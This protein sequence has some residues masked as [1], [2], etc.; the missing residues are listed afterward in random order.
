M[1][2]QLI[3]G[4]SGSGKST[5]AFDM[6]VRAAAEDRN[7]NVYVLV[8]DQFS[9]EATRTLV[10]K[11]N[12]GILNIDVLSFRRLAF[13]ALEE[14]EG[15]SRSIL[16]DEGKIMLLRKVIS[17]HKT[18]LQYFSKG[19]DRPGFLDECKSLL[20]EFIEYGIGD[21]ELAHLMTCFGEESRTALKLADLRLLRQ[22]L[23]DRLGETYRMA[24]E[25]IPMLTEMVPALSFLENATIC[26]DDF[27]GFTPVQFELLRALLTRCQDVIVTVTTDRDDRR[28]DVFAL[29]DATVEKLV[30]IASEQGVPVNDVIVTGD[31]AERNSY[32]LK[33]NPMLTYLE[34]HIFHED[35]PVYTGGDTSCIS[36]TACRNER[37][38]SL[39][40]ARQVAALLVKEDV[41][42]DRIAVV[43]G[44]PENYEP[45]LR[46]AFE[47]Y[48]IPYFIDQKKSL[49]MNPL[50]EFLLSFLYMLRRGFDRES[51]MRFLRGGLSA[52]TP[53]EVD[54]LENYM[55]ASG[56]WG[57]RSLQSEW[58]YD[59]SG[60][61][62]DRMD[63]LNESRERFLTMISE[64]VD[65]LR[66]GKK[67]VRTFT[68]ILVT[69]MVKNTCRIRLEEMADQWEESGDE[70]L[71]NEYRRIYPSMLGVMD[72]LVGLLGSEEVTSTE[73]TE[74]LRAGISEGVLGFVPPSRGQVLIGDVERS[75]LGDVEHLFF[76]GNTDAFFPKSQG[77]K[78]ILTDRERD[79]IDLYGE[80][81][82]IRL[83]PDAEELYGQELFYLYHLITRPTHKLYLTYTKN[84][85]SGKPVLP[86][87]LI[88]R[89]KELF[90]LQEEYVELGEARNPKSAWA[91]RLLEINKK[92]AEISKEAAEGLYGDTIKASITRFEKY[93]TCSYAH[94]LAYG[95]RVKE[96]EEYS[97]DPADRGNIFHNALETL[98]HKMT[99]EGLTWRTVRED[100][101]QSLGEASFDEE[102]GSRYREDVFGQDH[103]SAYMLRR[104][105]RVFL[106]TISYMHDQMLVGDFDQIAAEATFDSEPHDP[107]TFTSPLTTI[108]LAGKKQINLR[109]RIDRI[110]ACEINGTRYIKILDY[111]SSRKDLDLNK[112]YYGLEL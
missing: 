103:R 36:V 112:V 12:G 55:L 35:A 56:R 67:S 29:S 93:A 62:K 21:D 61:Y 19:L 110:D 42:P 99:D 74:I 22:E 23:E 94:F 13:R 33:G 45:Y 89:V 80:E 6:V 97:V 111:K 60:L 53:D 83:A 1:A 90:G 30:Q 4:V 48:G 17:D 66:G 72:T 38:E 106:K 64:A 101:L 87:Y 18:E 49:G 108:K 63:W 34:Q 40:V 85:A 73:Y 15:E 27:T 71:A 5:L 41:D 77:G 98:Y 50:A 109:G 44:A 102:S 51:V 26:L 95:L 57:Y 75:R 79:M 31:G 58:T 59:V 100:Q 92:N 70:L 20:S 11:N 84:D 86:S 68:E 10:Q 96:R 107:G 76:V 69:F 52:F 16:T 9:Q 24:E 54:L 3:T 82:G 65:A 7:R 81:I 14:Y 46:R 2:L 25:M 47:T 88:H 39:F 8:P 104:M 37:E 105:K 28:K 78:G 32:R 43:S 91:H